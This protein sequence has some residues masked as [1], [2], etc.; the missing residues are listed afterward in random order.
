M[1]LSSMPG[2]PSALS[3]SSRH[4]RA[5]SQPT[6]L[7]GTQFTGTAAQGVP[8]VE[9]CVPLCDSAGALTLD[10][11]HWLVPGAAVGGHGPCGLF[12]GEEANNSVPLLSRAV[13]A[14]VHCDLGY[15]EVTESLEFISATDINHLTFRFPVPVDC[16]LVRCARGRGGESVI[17]Q[18]AVQ[19]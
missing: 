12:G 13:K 16:C 11:A 14:L 19:H 6:L 10:L 4:T 2:S 1:A 9:P 8:P 3:N 15:A 17:A 5:R 7:N 18:G